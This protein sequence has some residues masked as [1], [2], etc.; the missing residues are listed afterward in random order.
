MSKKFPDNI[1]KAHILRAIEEIDEVGVRDGR[2]SSIYD[3]VYNDKSYPPK[4]II[5]IAHKFANGAELEAH[6]FQSG[7]NK[8][9]FELLEREGFK[10]IAKNDPIKSILEDYKKNI[11]ETKLEDE[12]YKWELIKTFKGRPN[13][14]ADDFFNNIKE[15]K[16]DNLIYHLSFAVLK[17]ITKA[18]PGHI[19]SLFKDLYDESKDL[20]ERIKD[21]DKETKA[22]YKELGKNKPHH[23]EERAIACYLTSFN[24]EKYTFYK[25]S[26]YKKYCKLLGIKEANK[27][28]KYDHYL[29]LVDELIENYISKDEE[30]ISQVKEYLGDLYDG[31]NHKLLAQDILF[32]MLDKKSEVNYWV[33]Q[34]SSKYFDIETAL[35]DEILTEWTIKAHKDKIQVGDKVIIW[36][37]GESPGCYALAEITSSPKEIN[38]SNDYHLWK[39]DFKSEFTA[40]IKITD[41]LVEKP[42]SKTE[43]DSVNSLKNL[44]IGKQG[45]NFTATKE[46][47]ENILKLINQKE[48]GVNMDSS[49]N[50][51]LYGPPGT[52][53]TYQ[54]IDKYYPIY[55]DEI[56]S[57]T[58]E[59]YISSLVGKYS[60][61]QIVA[62]VVYEMGSCKVPEIAEHILVKTK[63]ELSELKKLNPMIWA[64]LQTH[65]KQ[66]CS[67]VNYAKRSEPLFF[68]KKEDSSWVV[69][70][71]MVKEVTPEIIKLLEEYKNYEPRSERKKR[72]KTVT[73]HQSYSY[74]D[75]VEGLKPVTN[76]EDS[77]IVEYRVESGIFKSICKQ[78]DKDS[79]NNYA[80]FIDEIN[81][82][83]ISKIF[84][85][86]ITLIEPDK[87]KGQKNEVV[88]TL[89]YSKES[90]SVPPNL[91]IIG[92]MNTADR[93]IALMDTALR[94]RF[95]FV[96]IM[97]NPKLSDISEDIEGINCQLLLETVN[98]RIE[99]LYDR[100]HTIGHAYFIGIENK[101]NLDSI[102]MNKILPLLQ[103]YFYDDWEKIQIVL[104]DY[105]KQFS[106][107]S[108]ESINL[109][110]IINQHRFIQSRVV[111]EKSVLGF[112]SEYS[113]EGE[114][115]Y[116]VSEN[117]T[118]E[119]FKKVYDSSIYKTILNNEE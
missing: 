19:K 66:E 6:E 95:S 60:W 50:T 1:T 91:H 18:K 43:I 22:T 2:C 99:Y 59:E 8:P 52:G 49:P 97:P 5:S 77:T 116:K 3:L 41:N 29:E 12:K 86:L 96:E 82:G 14:E 84:G 79:D 39:K 117:F 119:C 57:I 35:K 7:P 105:H 42:L 69:D 72:Y 65:T 56:D 53:K 109:G 64:M 108:R 16:Y 58:K 81:R 88:V 87:R 94:R 83:N 73:F 100:D 34:G 90:F 107:S 92:T 27:N 44:N 48:S 110:E 98:K 54:L 31:V 33:F 26:F 104:G 20:T 76:S 93:S 46:E 75:F 9:A 36:M 45:T 4:L 106:S 101:R 67:L 70:K 80:L 13:V 118:L 10:I 85:E 115:Q 24:P 103:E 111:D 30:L 40:G 62:A 11:K 15:I 32:Q 102:M 51:I 113:D 55:T 112:T 61:W 78:A 63:H 17:E 25:N 28:E 68:E 21:F 23:Q 71:D 74:E 89:P 47:Y 114:T 37:S 38:S